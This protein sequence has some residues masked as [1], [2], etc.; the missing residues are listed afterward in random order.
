MEDPFIQEFAH[1]VSS[2]RVQGYGATVYIK[3]ALFPRSQNYLS[4]FIGLFFQEFQKPLPEIHLS[5]LSFF[6]Y[7]HRGRKGHRDKIKTT[8]RFE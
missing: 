6:P 3:V 2:F 5:L 4:L 1:Q 8:A 7:C